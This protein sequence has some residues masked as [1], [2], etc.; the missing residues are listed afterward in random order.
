MKNNSHVSLWIEA[1]DAVYLVRRGGAEGTSTTDLCGL[2]PHTLGYSDLAKDKD[3]KHLYRLTPMQPRLIPCVHWLAVPLSALGKPSVGGMLK[4]IIVL[5]IA[6]GRLALEEGLAL[7][8]AILTR[9]M[10]ESDGAGGHLSS[11]VVSVGGQ[12]AIPSERL[13]VLALA[14]LVDDPESQ[15]TIISLSCC[16]ARK[17]RRR[18]ESREKHY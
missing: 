9:G 8:C 7:L 14:C 4:R 17:P 18:E 12:V 6:P 2:R 10:L 5:G 13:D 11:P 3:W 15:T 1:T 16:Q